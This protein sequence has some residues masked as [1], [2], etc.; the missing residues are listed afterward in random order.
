MKNKIFQAFFTLF[1]PLN[2]N[3]IEKWNKMK[4]TRFVHLKK[5]LYL[6][7]LSV[8]GTL[9]PLKIPYALRETSR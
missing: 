8:Q 6:Y 2:M 3:S 9:Q 1:N 7:Y 4:R 5:K